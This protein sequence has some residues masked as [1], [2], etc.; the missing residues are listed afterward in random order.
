MIGPRDASGAAE[1]VAGSGSKKASLG[2]YELLAR[3]AA[4]GMAEVY[5]ARVRGEGGFERLVAVKR[6]LANIASDEKF[7]EMFL[8]EG[9]ISGHIESPHVV[10]VYDVGRDPDGTLFIAM[11]LVR[12]VALHHLLAPVFKAG[13]SV[14]VGIAVSLLAQAAD[15]LGAAHDA[16]TPLGE[17]LEVVHRDVSPQNIL[18]GIDGRARVADFGI[19]RAVHRR[20]NTAT[21]ELKG[22]LA[23]FAPEQLRAKPADARSDVFALAVVAWETVAARRLFQGEHPFQTVDQIRMHEPEALDAIRPDVPPALATAIARGL[24]KDPERRTESARVFADELRAAVAPASATVVA[25]FVRE[26][27]GASVRALDEQIKA[28]LGGSGESGLSAPAP[29]NETSGVVATREIE[30]VAAAPPADAGTVRLVGAAD[31][32]RTAPLAPRP[33]AVEPDEPAKLAA[34]AAI[35]EATRPL[36]SNPSA[37]AGGTGIALALVALF[38]LVVSTLAYA[39]FGTERTVATVPLQRPVPDRNE[40]GPVSA[41]SVA[42]PHDVVPSTRV[43]APPASALDR[44]PAPEPR[45]T[46]ARPST[47]SR[48]TRTRT[49]IPHEAPVTAPAATTLPEATPVEPVHRGLRGADEFRRSV[50][51][52]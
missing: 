43:V 8:D 39:T 28:A 36:P 47:P 19:A 15:G 29:G 9:R 50:V 3:I 22:K 35:E 6:M 11:E 44:P 10:Q 32:A 24:I 23:Y 45:G 37:R 13:E 5:V 21:G 7:A 40:V 25:A 30:F 26:W 52:P 42:E 48:T 16:T 2:R 34:P 46:D 41:P 51:G 12:G 31:A 14:P 20:T 49:R 27:A 4:G 38:V 18:V 33:L 1:P 17:R